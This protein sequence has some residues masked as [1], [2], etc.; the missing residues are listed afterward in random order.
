VLPLKRTSI[1]FT[2]FTLKDMIPSSSTTVDHL[3]GA[4]VKNVQSFPAEVEL[5]AEH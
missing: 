4:V 2:Y 3:L 5:L 1:K